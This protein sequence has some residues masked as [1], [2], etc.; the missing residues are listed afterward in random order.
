MS[1]DSLV[2]RRAFSVR[3]AHSSAER[4]RRKE[5]GK[6]PH[7]CMMLSDT[8]TRAGQRTCLAARSIA[9]SVSGHMQRVDDIALAWPKVLLTN[10]GVDHSKWKRNGD[11]RE[12]GQ[13]TEQCCQQDIKGAMTRSFGVSSPQ[14][15]LA[16]YPVGIEH[17]SGDMNVTFE[18]RVMNQ[19][20]AE[21][22]TASHCARSKDRV[23]ESRRPDTCRISTRVRAATT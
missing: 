8:D 2:D 12:N 23:A 7:E 10:D 1:R 6:G 9:F 19:K 15:C 14:V 18:S 11:G 22:T 4:W 20:F 16:E 3:L 17:P 21:L 13:E 5:I